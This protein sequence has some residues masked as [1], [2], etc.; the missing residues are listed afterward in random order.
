MSVIYQKEIL[1][2]SLPNFH[3]WHIA[4]CAFLLI[5]L[6]PSICIAQQNFRLQLKSPVEHAPT[7]EKIAPKGTIYADS[8]AVVKV[9]Q[10]LLNGFYSQGFLESSIDSVQVQDSVF[11][12]VLTCGKQYN[13]AQLRNGNI[14]PEW[15]L[16]S[17]FRERLY[18]GKPFH[19]SELAEL[20]EALVQTA[21]N[22]GFPFASVWLDSIE[23]SPG[24]IAA[25]IMMD[26]GRLMLF[27]GVNIIGEV[28][29]S[30]VYLENYLG[31]KKGEPF[32]KSKLLK[33]KNRINE[34]PFLNEKTASTVTFTGSK[35]T[36]NLFLN[37]KK[38]SRWDFLIGILPQT[39]SQEG[40]PARP[41]VTASVLAD[42]Y[43]QFSAG[44]R[45]Y[46]SFEQLQPQ[47]QELNTAFTYPY[48]LDLP[49]GLD[50][51]FDIY[52]RD[53]SFTD[54]ISDFGIQY[55]FEGNNYLKV[56][57]NN[58]S[59]FVQNVDTQSIIA[60]KRLPDVLDIS[61]SSFGLESYF[62]K[63]DYRFN[64]RKGWSA[65]VRAGAGFKRI[66]EN[67]TISQIRADDFL[68]SSLYDTL[69][70][71]TFQ[72][73]F[74]TDFQTFIPLT[75]R[76][77]FK[78]GLNSSYILAEQPILQNEQF[79]IG[80]NRLL[81]GFNE[82]E[83]NATLYSVLTLEYRLLISTNS[84]LYAFGD[85]A[86]VEDVT[87]DRSRSDRPMSFGAGMTFETAVGLFGFSLAVGRQQQN[88]ID[89]R[90]PKIH[91]GYVSFF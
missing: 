1:I 88:P 25:A 41:L 80:G 68:G 22:S 28:K 21:E 59:S 30:K 57:W 60:S 6:V 90:N 72:Y 11:H 53:S 63:L 46:F 82:E 62:Q 26:R 10:D 27:E 44:E 9:M 5:I 71:Q 15:L 84:Y 17:G 64:P 3:K 86:Y 33:I 85:L 58:R 40:E 34:L 81:R 29:I 32:D 91:F 49:F 67:N 13:W 45:I 48:L 37:K 7:V 14:E 2:G 18:T 65:K 16:Q 73:R 83:I 47:R 12:A 42:L 54:V 76:S 61:N 31:I 75:L 74:E 4:C 38:S 77:T 39:P 79:R 87:V 20:L 51:S 69:D 89:F 43:N 78:V 8:L 35:A 56:F 52:R 24:E 55:L 66:K 23:I 36:V 70:V 50:L 19:Y